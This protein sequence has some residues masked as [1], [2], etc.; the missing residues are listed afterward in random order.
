MNIYNPEPDWAN[1]SRDE[2]ET[3]ALK[4]IAWA[5]FH[6]GVK[7]YNEYASYASDTLEYWREDI[8]EKASESIDDHDARSDFV[9]EALKI[10]YHPLAKIQW[11][12]LI[13]EDHFAE[14]L[15][16]EKAQCD[17]EKEHRNIDAM[18]L[19]SPDPISK[20]SSSSMDHAKHVNNFLKFAEEAVMGPKK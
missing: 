13:E 14:V 2:L 18:T 11:I 15:R 10:N 19:I 9:Y 12:F 16:L 4:E 1:P 5:D 20:I 3:Q 8:A 6:A 17:L 7:K